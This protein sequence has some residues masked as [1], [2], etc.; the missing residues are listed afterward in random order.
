ME[1]LYLDV[2]ALYRLGQGNESSFGKKDLGKLP[3]LSTLLLAG[4]G[5][6]WTFI[7]IYVIQN[8]I[9]KSKI[10]SKTGYT[11]EKD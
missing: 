7:L 4:L 3:P 10:E 11:S 2:T 9:K 1:K 8:T 5:L 6:I